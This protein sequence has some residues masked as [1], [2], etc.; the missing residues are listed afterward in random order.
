MSR[1]VRMVPKFF[2]HPRDERGSLIPL[3]DGYRRA[4][5]E[6]RS[7][8]IAKGMQATLD[9]L[10]GAPDVHDYMPETL[11]NEKADHF[12]MY[13]TVSEGTPISPVC[14]SAEELA[15]WLVDNKGNA[16]AGATATYEQWLAMIKRGHSVG[17]FVLAGGRL[18][19]GVEAAGEPETR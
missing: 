4:H 10:G 11:D 15:R 9:D 3:N 17:S 18:I 6:W 16:G 13:E 2:E 12:V 19:S 5:D 8:F 7:S 14:A 1:K